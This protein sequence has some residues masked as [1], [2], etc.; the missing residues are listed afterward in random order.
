M[1]S[2]QLPADTEGP[3]RLHGRALHRMEYPSPFMGQRS[4]FRPRFQVPGPSPDDATGTCFLDDHALV[5]GTD[6]GMLFLML[7]RLPYP[8]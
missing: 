7:R 2:I 5:V 3:A 8:S 1:A 6:S 4:Q